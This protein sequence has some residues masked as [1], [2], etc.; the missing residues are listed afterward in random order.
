MPISAKAVALLMAINGN[1]NGASVR[2]GKN[3]M[4]AASGLS[5][6]QLGVHIGHL[7]SMGLLTLD[8]RGGGRDGDGSTAVYHL[9]VPADT[10]RL[11]V[12]DMDEHG[13]LIPDRPKRPAPKGRP[14]RAKR[15]EVNSASPQPG[16]V[17]TNDVKPASGETPSAPE[18]EVKQSSPQNVAEPRIEVKPPS[19]E[20]QVDVKHASPENEFQVKREAD[21]GEAE[22]ALMRS[23]L[24]TTKMTMGTKPQSVVPSTGPLTSEA[25][26]DPAHDPHGPTAALA[27]VAEVKAAQ[28][29]L[30]DFDDDGRQALIHAAGSEL[31]AEGIPVTARG[32]LIR[33][34]DIATRPAPTNDEGH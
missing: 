30:D 10:T 16:A 27:L 13:R 19:P 22:T 29:V 2:P 9:S 28:A 11:P 7:E 20:N 25:P 15:F 4:L 24:R 17:P 14:V 12:L 32:L 6:K 33:A 5:A 21:S 26:P 31:R 3:R 23:G 8:R 34:A 1:R 18:V